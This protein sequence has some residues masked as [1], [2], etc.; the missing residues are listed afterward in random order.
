MCVEA[1]YQTNTNR[2]FVFVFVAPYENQ[3]R[4]IFNRLMEL[5]NGSPM[6]KRRLEGSTRNP[7]QIRFKDNSRIVGFT[8][9]AS[10]NSGGA[11]IRGQRA[12]MIACD[13]MDYLGEG[14][15]ENISMLAAEREDIRICVSSTPTGKRGDFYNCCTNPKAGYHEH[16]HP[17]THN[18]NWSEQMEAEFR[19]ELTELGYTHEVLAEFG[20]QDTGVFKKECVDRAM[21]FDNYA[22]NELDR[23]QL[24]RIERTNEE[25]PVMYLPINNKFKRNVF[26]TMGVDWDKT[27]KNGRHRYKFDIVGG[28][29]MLMDINQAMNTSSSIYKLKGRKSDIYSLE[30]SN[31]RKLIKIYHFLYDGASVFLDRKKEVFDNLLSRFTEM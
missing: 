1:L 15:F 4:L 16:Y 19:A 31:K 26:R 13:E 7:Y 2:E 25:Y 29:D 23:L 30:V 28:L 9:G 22:Y 20:D 10:S 14:D 24:D 5:V 27:D 21:T 6:L 8:T 11:S 17:S 12:N 18:P 3:I